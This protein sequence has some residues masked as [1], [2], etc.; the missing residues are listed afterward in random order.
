[1]VK[2]RFRK[3]KSVESAIIDEILNSADPLFLQS[4]EDEMVLATI[5][6]EQRP[7]ASLLRP[8]DDAR[9]SG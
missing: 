1:M 7:S 2:K 8:S 4:I 6:D 5:P 9:H 3:A